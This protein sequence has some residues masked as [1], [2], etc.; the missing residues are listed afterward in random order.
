MVLFVILRM[1]YLRLI[2]PINLLLTALAMYCVRWFI[3]IPLLKNCVID[4]GYLS[5]YLNEG[6][7]LLLV[8]SVVCI[9][10]AGYIINDF[11]DVETD[12]LNKPDKVVITK[13][14]SYSQASV[15][16]YTLNIIGILLGALVAFK[17]RSFHLASVQVAAAGLLWLYAMQ[18]KKRPVIGNVAIAL[19]SAVAVLMPVFYEPIIFYNAQSDFDSVLQVILLSAS[20]FAVFAF[21]TQ[22]IREIIKDLQDLEGDKSTDCNTLPIWLSVKATK[23]VLAVLILITMACVGWF[24]FHFYSHRHFYKLFT[25]WNIYVS[26]L[27]QLPLLFVLLNLWKAEKPQQ[28]NVLSTTIKVVMLAGMISMVFIQQWFQNYF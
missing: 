3:I 28:Y 9:N 13:S 22:W 20:V 1:D 12:K 8:L 16:Y 17:I 6:W 5:P 18:L 11:C 7:F 26:V 25:I 10:S 15:Y 24:Q 2:R 4:E 21:L 27:L 19:L 14:V 23:I